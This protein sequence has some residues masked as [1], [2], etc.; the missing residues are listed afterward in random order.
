M[1]DNVKL[2]SPGLDSCT[3]I[4][5]KLSELDISVLAKHPEQQMCSYV[6]HKN[7]QHLLFNVSLQQLSLQVLSSCYKF[8]SLVLTCY[9]SSHSFTEC[10]S[11]FSFGRNNNLIQ[12]KS[13]TWQHF[14]CQNQTFN[15]S[16][17]CKI[18]TCPLPS[19]TQH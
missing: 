7:C 2:L 16:I 8:I 6:S 15:S 10:N 3:T 1:D 12:Q 13:N 5:K 19:F 17:W 14:R 18:I 11:D 4:F 9:Y